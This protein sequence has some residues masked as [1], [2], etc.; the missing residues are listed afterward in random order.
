MAL[1]VATRVSDNWPFI[2]SNRLIVSTETPEADAKAVCIYLQSAAA[3]AAPQENR[4]RA[5][6]AM[7]AAAMLSASQAMTAEI[8]QRD[9]GN[10]VIGG[11]V[12]DR[13]IT[14]SGELVKG[15]ADKFHMAIS[16][17]DHLLVEL[18]GP[19][20]LLEEG[21]IIGR[22]V[23]ARHFATGVAPDWRCLSA[24]AIAWLAGTP[25]IAARSA[26]ILFH[27]PWHDEGTS[28]LDAAANAILGA[29]LG[30]LGL[31]ETAIFFMTEK[32]KDE[33]NFLTEETAQAYGIETVFTG[34]AAPL[35]RAIATEKLVRGALVLVCRFDRRAPYASG[36]SCVAATAESSI[37]VDVP[38]LYCG[39]W[40]PGYGNEF[41]ARTDREH[42]VKVD[43]GVNPRARLR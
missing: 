19:G 32:G 7:I 6:L 30:S 8:T 41:G 21:L 13:V 34:K 39:A 26:T 29:Y 16:G 25:R 31:G 43:C 28:D 22:E 37:A 33:G 1:I 36:E 42:G 3:L 27:H 5:R 18:N 35:S 2:P 40:V 17:F 12:F 9:P 20:G 15:D 4:M 24:C 11:Y 14:V 10:D 38:P 23:R